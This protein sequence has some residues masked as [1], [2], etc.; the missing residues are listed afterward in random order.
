ITSFVLY[1]LQSIYGPLIRRWGNPRKVLVA[2]CDFEVCL[3][4]TPS[5][6]NSSWPPNI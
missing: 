6:S 2:R 4:V 1:S 3:F 5:P